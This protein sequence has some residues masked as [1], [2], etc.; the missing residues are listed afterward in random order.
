MN[1]TLDTHT[2]YW[3]M[4]K[5][6]NNKLSEKALNTIKLAESTGTI[7]ISIITFLEILH[8][9]ENKSKLNISFNDLLRNIE[10]LNNYSII[11]FDV[12][13]LKISKELKNLESHDRIILATSIFTDSTL[14]SKDNELLNKGYNV[15]W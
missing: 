15:I 9:S 3:Y 6:L 7:Y 4:V 14:I 1:I 5:E 11:S 2:L 8:L 13:I 12:N 10:A